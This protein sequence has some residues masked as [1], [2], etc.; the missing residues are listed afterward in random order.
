MTAHP[1]PTFHA[2]AKLAMQAPPEKLAYTVMLSPDFSQ[3]DALG[4]VDVDPGSTSS[5]KIVHTVVHAQQRRRVSPFWLET[6][7]HRR[8]LRLAVTLSWSVAT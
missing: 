7:A 8:C 1:D 3:P 6:H 4:V 5:G 2:T